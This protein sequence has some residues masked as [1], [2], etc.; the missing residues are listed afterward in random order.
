MGH[1]L[2]L[3]SLVPK[4]EMFTEKY[5][6]EDSYQARRELYNG[7]TFK[8]DLDRRFAWLDWCLTQ[9]GALPDA[10]WPV[11]GLGQIAPQ[12]VSS[13]GFEIR[14][15]SPD[16][17][18]SIASFLS[19]IDHQTLRSVV[20]ADHMTTLGLYKIQGHTNAEVLPL[21]IDDFDGLRAFYA[22]VSKVG[23]AVVIQKY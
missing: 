17:C 10:T 2:R 21:I 14:W 18:V 6:C 11:R 7:A 5:W 1:E 9:I 15:N 3:Y 12:A 23:E 20:D 8:L 19:S 16:V 13:Q 4:P 22:A